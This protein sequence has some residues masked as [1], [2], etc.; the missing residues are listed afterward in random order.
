MNVYHS[1]HECT[2]DNVLCISSK[3]GP[4]CNSATFSIMVADPAADD[5]IAVGLNSTI[6]LLLPPLPSTILE[7]NVEIYR[8]YIIYIY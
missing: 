1:N 7:C 5:V 3:S 8:V 2:S 6:L 4:N